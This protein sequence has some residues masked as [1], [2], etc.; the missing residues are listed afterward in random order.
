[1]ASPITENT[2]LEMHVEL[3][4]ERYTRL[5]E[6]FKLVEHRLDQLHTDFSSFKNE[7]QKNLSE[8]KSMLTG[9][10]DEKFKIMV[11]STATIIVGLLAMLGY[12]ITHLPK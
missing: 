9:A 8:I 3:C 7:N 2:S 4:A 12:V 6:K 5:E 11:G 1:M 10:K